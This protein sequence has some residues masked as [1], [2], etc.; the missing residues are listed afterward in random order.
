MPFDL[1]RGLFEVIAVN[2]TQK[3]VTDMARAPWRFENVKKVQ[4]V[5]IIAVTSAYRPHKTMTL[6]IPAGDAKRLV[7]QIQAALS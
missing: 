6:T 5:L 7:E 2:D 1:R 3:G 4:D